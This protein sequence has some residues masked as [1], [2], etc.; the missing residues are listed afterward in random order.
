MSVHNYAALF[1]AA[2][3]ACLAPGQAAHGQT[4]AERAQVSLDDAF[5]RTLG[6]TPVLKAT[7]AAREAADGVGALR[8]TVGHVAGE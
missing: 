5:A 8:G 3:V 1:G 7:E 2:C 6:Q 4:S